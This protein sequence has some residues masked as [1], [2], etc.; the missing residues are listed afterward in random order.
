MAESNKKQRFNNHAMHP[1]NRKLLDEWSSE[2]FKKRDYKSPQPAQ[3]RIFLESSEFI[4]RPFSTFR[5]ADIEEYIFKLV[6]E[7]LGNS[8]I[9][10]RI[11]AI[12]AFRKYLVEDPKYPKFNASF[13]PNLNN[14]RREEDKSK[15]DKDAALTLKQIVY[16]RKFF[17]QSPRK[18]K[19]QEY[20]FEVYYQLGIQEKEIEVCIPANANFDKGCFI[21]TGNEPIEYNEKIK[22]L[23]G[24]LSDRDITQLKPNSS[25]RKFETIDDKLKDKYSNDFRENFELGYESI[26]NSRKKYFMECP[27]CGRHV[28]NIAE[29]WVLLELDKD[30]ELRLVCNMCK[31]K[32]KP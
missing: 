15:K 3:V 24:Q 14:L 11:S 7:K 32:L 8:S 31:G 27:E 18:Y 13:L 6:Q 23:F 25:K 5:M 2:I 1:R 17:A 28:E 4:D 16:L 19:C 30:Q 9:N 26:K 12:K 29:N 10:T 22:S 21:T 20:M